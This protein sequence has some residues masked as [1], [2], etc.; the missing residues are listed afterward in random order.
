MR[1]LRLSFVYTGLYRTLLLLMYYY[2]FMPTILL[3]PLLLLVLLTFFSC[4]SVYYIRLV[5]ETGA[6][7]DTFRKMLS[8]ILLVQL[9]HISIVVLDIVIL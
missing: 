7:C 9:F 3:V 4:F 6:G 1:A 2:I 5:G 8:Y